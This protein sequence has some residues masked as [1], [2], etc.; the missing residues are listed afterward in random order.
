MKIAVVGATGLVGSVMTRVLEERH[1]PV[2]SFFPVASG[3]SK[4]KKVSF[5]DREYAVMPLSEA[6][7]LR[8]DIALFSAGGD[9]SREWAPRFAEA[10]ITVIDNSNAWRMHEDIPLIVPEVNG[11]LLKSTD[12]I[13]ANPNC[14]TIQLVMILAPLHRLYGIRRVIVSTYQSVT[15]TGKKAVDQLK[16]ERRGEKVEQIYPHPIDLNAIPH[17][18]IFLDNGYTR[19]EMKLLQESRKIMDVP[20]LALTATAVRLPISGGHSEA[21]N[22]EFGGDYDLEV[23][24]KTLSETPGVVVQ[25]QPGLNQYPMPRLAEGRDEVFVG[26]LRRIHRAVRH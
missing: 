21:V 14:S 15:G 11:H 19:E 18:G 22:V 13:I 4:G 20:D 10:G 25:D 26:R 12:K 23:V 17:C 24:R 1:F 6:L 3:R 8:P 5:R 9:T 16:G 2:T 7:G